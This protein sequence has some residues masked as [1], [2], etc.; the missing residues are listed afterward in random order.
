MTPE[1]LAHLQEHEREFE[2]IFDRSVDEYVAEYAH[3]D[4]LYFSLCSDLEIS[5]R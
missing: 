1:Q 3:I 4:D 5:P 2:E